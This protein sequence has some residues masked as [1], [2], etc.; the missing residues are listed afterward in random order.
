M[1]LV[2]DVRDLPANNPHSG[3]GDA[4][5]SGPAGPGLD[6]DLKTVKTKDIQDVILPSEPA[7]VFSVDNK[8]STCRKFIWKESLLSTL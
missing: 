3:A 6:G 1:I 4:P 5:H 7:V 2:K 8:V